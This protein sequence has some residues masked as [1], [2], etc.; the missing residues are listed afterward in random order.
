M[1]KDEG[2]KY[3]K[4]RKNGGEGVVLTRRKWR[5][6]GGADVETAEKARETRT[7]ERRETFIPY[8]HV[9]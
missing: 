7:R 3:I 1:E 9:G 2:R 6:K 8:Q 4:V 5:K